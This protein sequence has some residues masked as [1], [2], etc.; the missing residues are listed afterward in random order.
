[1]QTIFRALSGLAALAVV[2]L[3]G[4]AALHQLLVASNAAKFPPPGAF[5][6]FESR[7]LH[8]V[9]RGAGAPV[10]IFESG[11]GTDSQLSWARIANEL[12]AHTRA[13]YYDRAGYGWSDGAPPPRSIAQIA[14]ELGAVIDAAAGDAPVILVGH[15]LGGPMIRAYANEHSDRVAGMVF[16]DSSHEEQI[17]RLPG[18]ADAPR[19]PDWRQRYGAWL[20]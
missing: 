8:Y 3:A 17:T 9:C 2:A 10:V 15:S 7:R 4:A 16:V 13:C 19:P 18:A 6:E 12:S 5:A 1:M 14:R 20:A 11:L